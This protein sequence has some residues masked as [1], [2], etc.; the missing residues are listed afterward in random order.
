M[1]FWILGVGAL[2]LIGLT[3]WIMWPGASAPA[4]DATATPAADELAVTTPTATTTTATE[5]APPSKPAPVSAPAP[6]V[7]VQ[8][9]PLSA[10]AAPLGAPVEATPSAPIAAHEIGVAVKRGEQAPLRTWHV[11][12][13]LLLTLAGGVGGALL[14]QRW[15]QQRAKRARRR[16]F[17]R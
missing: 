14:H 8:A 10:P 11:V 3:I 4:G 6:S 17:F 5:K 16:F 13:G 12:T 2:V 7:K 1:E 15:Q 9:R